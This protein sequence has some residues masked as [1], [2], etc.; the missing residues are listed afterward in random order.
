MTKSRVEHLSEED[1]KRH[2]SSQ[3]PLQSLLGTLSEERIVA[4]ASQDEVWFF[5]FPWKIH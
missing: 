1:K 4:Q 2:K 5:A 3:S